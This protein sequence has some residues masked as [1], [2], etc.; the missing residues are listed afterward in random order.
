MRYIR[1][2]SRDKPILQSVIRHSEREQRLTRALA[3]CDENIP[4]LNEHLE[5]IFSIEEHRYAPV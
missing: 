3:P 5:E 4:Y 1:K 2:D